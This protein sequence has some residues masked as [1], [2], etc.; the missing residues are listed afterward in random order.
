MRKSR[1]SPAID[2]TVKDFYRFLQVLPGNAFSSTEALPFSPKRWAV[3]HP[4]GMAMCWWPQHACRPGTTA[5]NHQI[6]EKGAGENPAPKQRF[7]AL[8]QV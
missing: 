6:N 8:L 4:R 1:D 7:V 2:K 5:K 3:A